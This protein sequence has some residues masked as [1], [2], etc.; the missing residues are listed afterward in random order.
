MT[1]K[2]IVAMLAGAAMAVSAGAW[3]QQTT[4]F[5]AGLDVGNADI[6]SDDDTGW[7]IFGGYQF[8]R[9]VAAELGISRLYDKGGAKVEA[10]ELVAVG[11]APL[12]DKISLYGKLG[13]A[14]VDFTPGDDK[15]ELTVGFGVQYDFTRNLGVR[16]QWQRYDTDPDAIDFVSVGVLWKF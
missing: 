1:K 7:K 2:W 14:N 5:Y 4:G 10:L 13:F 15:T 3:A 8:H 6:G 12:A 16:A 11:I 9:N